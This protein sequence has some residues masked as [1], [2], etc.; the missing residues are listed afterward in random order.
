MEEERE[1]SGI[2]VSEI[3]RVIFSQ[4]WLVLIITAVIAV[5]GT[6]GIYF[7]MNNSRREYVASFV[8]NLPG[9]DGTKSDYVYPDGNTFFYSDIVSRQKLR[10]VKASDPEKF[11]DV[12]VDKMAEGGNISI[13]RNRTQVSANADTYETT[14]TISVKASYFN[15]KSV[16]TEFIIAL[17]NI[18]GSYLT[19]MDIDYDRYIVS[20]RNANNYENVVS[21]LKQ[22]L[23]DYLVKQYSQLIEEYK[24]DFVINE[25]KTLQNYMQNVTEYLETNVLDNL[26]TEAREKGFLKDASLVD[27]YRVEI[28]Q[29]KKDY[30]DAKF[31]LESMQA[32]N[33]ENLQNAEV[34]AKQAEKVNT[35]KRRV[36]ALE[37]YIAKAD[38]ITSDAYKAEIAVYEAKI[39]KAYEEV[40]RF[41]ADFKVAAATVYGTSSMVS[42]A[43]SNIVSVNGETGL[44]ISFAISLV[45]GLIIAMIVGYI[46][47]RVKLNKKSAKA[48]ARTA[49]E[50]V[51]YPAE[52]EVISQAAAA[53][54]DGDAPDKSEEK[55]KK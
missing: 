40:E 55:K 2:S 4:K 28:I 47:G 49:G 33:N 29:A 6:L 13:S 30:E 50:N 12:D 36:E 43:T 7:G 9:D 44:I 38:L 11:K 17:A 26:I 3:F 20:A 18:P 39:A 1:E 41:T 46:V 52:A 25:G 48:A 31:V 27:E 24:P 16:A 14:Y 19:E 10:E 37:N 42:F 54:D 5:A 21:Y 35:L 23:E 51:F 32:G 34:I 22:Q 8:L 45:A 15:D 53:S